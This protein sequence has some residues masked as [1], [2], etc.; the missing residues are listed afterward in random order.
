VTASGRRLRYQW[1]KNREDIPGATSASYT[2]PAT[3]LWDTGSAF[4]CVVSNPFGKARSDA[5]ILNPG[6]D[7]TGER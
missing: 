5:A 6:A 1:Q 2:T 4:R 7:G 3:T